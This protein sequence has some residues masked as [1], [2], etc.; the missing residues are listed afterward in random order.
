M[1]PIF[2][3]GGA[4]ALILSAMAPLAYAQ[5]TNTHDDDHDDE[6]VM[7]KVVVSTTRS[8]RLAQDEPVKVEVIP[9]EEIE[10]K[11]IMRPGNIATLVNETGGIRVQVTSPALGA[12]NVRIQGLFGRYTQI[13]ADGLPLYGGQASSLGLLQIPPTDLRQVDVI[14]GSASSLYGA[15]ALGGVIN[16]LS[17]TPDDEPEGEVLFNVTSR[18]GQDVTGYF[19]TPL[20][21]QLGVSLTTGAHRQGLQDFDNDGWI[22]MPKYERW[23]ARPRLFWEDDEGASLYAT[24]GFMSEQRT[25]GTRPGATVADGTSFVQAQDTKRYDAGLVGEKE[26]TSELTAQLRA[27][28]M[29]QDHTHQFGNVIEDDTHESYL[30]ETSLAGT[31]FNTS[32]VLGAAWQ[33]DVYRSDT[34][35]QFDYTYEVPGIFTQL[36]HELTDDLTLSL[37]MR[38]DDHNV[39]GSQ[40]SPRISALYRPGNW[41]FRGSFG[42]GFFAPTPFVEEIEAAGLSRLDPLS[43]LTEEKAKTASLDI[44]YRLGSLETNVTLF[45][46]DVENVTILDAYASTSGGVEDRVRLINS[47][48]TTRMRGS[49]FLLRYT[50]NDFKVTGSYLYIDS[51]EPDREAAGRNEVPLTPRHTAGMVA[52]WERHGEF[53]LGLEMYYSGEQRVEDNPYRTTSDAY[54]DVGILGEITVGRASW[55]INAE[56]LLDVRQTREEPL[57]RPQR[58]SSGQWTNDIWSR[59]DGLIINGGVRLK[60]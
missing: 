18:N 20:T 46:S 56:N 37:S 6:A 45:A 12:A 23:T 55:F 11:A 10:E 13:L 54:L 50:W 39:Y 1:S 16:L 34:F 5:D 59:N 33:S 8:G 29:V 21:E 22:D 15:S 49:E 48:G 35:P 51:S 27:S 36:D 2:Q 19:A 38:L 9:Q 42:K 52:M 3:W 40:F 43:N 26:L 31:T 32:W 58:S 53:R 44:G 25:G 47:D 14:K 24:F 41:T 30:F 4:A 60:F 17:R 28:A 57:L 7:K